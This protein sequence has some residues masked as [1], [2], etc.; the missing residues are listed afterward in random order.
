MVVLAGSRMGAHMDQVKQAESANEPASRAEGPLAAIV[1]LACEAAWIAGTK[2]GYSATAPGDYER[3][4]AWGMRE[5]ASIKLIEAEIQA[6]ARMSEAEVKAARDRLLAALKQ[7]VGTNQPE[8]AKDALLAACKAA[9]PLLRADR[10]STFESYEV[11]GEIPDEDARHL[12][13]QYDAAIDSG[14]AAIEKAG[15]VA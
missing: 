10:D 4:S 7:P 11:D 15:G 14:V 5:A 2:L 6:L 12:I 13:A 9:L 1:K 3:R 8:P